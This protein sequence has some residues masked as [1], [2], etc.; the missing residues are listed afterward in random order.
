MIDL[1]VYQYERNTLIHRESE[2]KTNFQNKILTNN[3]FLYTKN[4]SNNDILRL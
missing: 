2:L 3:Y 4:A 1:H